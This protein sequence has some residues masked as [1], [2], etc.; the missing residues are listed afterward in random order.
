MGACAATI[1][2]WKERLR[3]GM[4]EGD[5]SHV[6]INTL[7]NAIREK[8]CDVGKYRMTRVY[9]VFSLKHFNM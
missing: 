3:T 1:K 4:N 2:N 8:M 6:V 7:L 9:I 5:V